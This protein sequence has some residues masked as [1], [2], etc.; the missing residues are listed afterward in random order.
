MYYY[1]LVSILDSAMSNK[2]QQYQMR[3]MNLSSFPIFKIV[4][5]L[6]QAAS[7]LVDIA[8]LFLFIWAWL[9]AAPLAVFLTLAIVLLGRAWQ[10]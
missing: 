5:L 7:I 3:T 10:L 6:P 1:F 9:T 4:V 2:H 8:F